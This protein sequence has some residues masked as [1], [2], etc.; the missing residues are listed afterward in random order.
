[1]IALWSVG[2]DAV[3]C[4]TSDVSKQQASL[5]SKFANIII[6]F[7]GHSAGEKGAK[8]A[9]GL[10]S[11]GSWIRT[12][13]LPPGTDPASLDP[14]ILCELVLTAGYSSSD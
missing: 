14:E 8:K 6:L 11:G 3:S 9:A 10:L 7:N 1:V 2:T 4:P 13:H 5:L 12:V